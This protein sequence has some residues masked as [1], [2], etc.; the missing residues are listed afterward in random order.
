MMNK[1]NREQKLCELRKQVLEMIYRAK[2]G[3]IGGDFS[4]IDILYVLYNSIMKQNDH[5]ILSK[6]HCVEALYAV[7]ADKGFFSAE[8]L[9]S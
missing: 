6:G 7:L 5:F 1:I 2:S 9:E 3:H 8:E 4:V